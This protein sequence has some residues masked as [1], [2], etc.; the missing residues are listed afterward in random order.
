ML[1]LSCECMSIRCDKTIELSR[2]EASD[3]QSKRLVLIV[4]GCSRGPE[5][6]DKLVEKRCGYGL[7]EEVLDAP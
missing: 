7:Y 2:Q 4:D 6:T 3:Y 5:P 1:L